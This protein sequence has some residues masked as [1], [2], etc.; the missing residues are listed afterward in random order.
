[1]SGIEI[2]GIV[3]GALPIL[4]EALDGYRGSINRISQ[5]VRKRKYVEKLARALRMQRQTLESILKIVLLES[6]CESLPAADEHIRDCLNDPSNK[7]R[8]KDYLGVQN[9]LAFQDAVTDC[10]ESVHRATLRVAAYVP[11]V[12]VESMCA[13]NWLR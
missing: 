5:G 7:A 10:F 8:V 12:K 9:D 4:F 13:S 6:G 11:L 2:A 1:M 3:L